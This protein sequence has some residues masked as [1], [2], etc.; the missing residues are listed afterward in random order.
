MKIM[1]VDDH[2][3][4]RSGMA[5]TLKSLFDGAE[6]I[7]AGDVARL[8]ALLDNAETPPDLL[9]LD[10]LFPGFNARVDFPALRRRLPVTPMIVVSM[11]YDNDLIEHLMR[12]GANGFVSKAAPPAELSAAILAVMD[13]ETVVRRAA[14]PASSEVA[15]ALDDPLGALSPRQLDVMR[16]VAQGLSNK[17]I[18]RELEISP[19]T[20][21]IHVSAALRALGLANRSA[22]ASYAA[23]RGLG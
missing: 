13:G 4:F 11:I 21:R 2:P 5:M 7:E 19:Y 15:T 14:G 6:I 3:V 23:S 18:A 20:V 8:N 12:A 16:R 22:L 9:V 1:L 17:E 10:L